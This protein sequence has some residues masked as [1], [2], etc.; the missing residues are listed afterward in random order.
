VTKALFWIT[1]LLDMSIIIPDDVLHSARLTEAEIRQELA[2]ALF[3]K[4][5][6][7]LGQASE[8]AQ[9]SAAD[10]QHLLAARRISLHYDVGDL[11]ADVATLRDS[12][13][14]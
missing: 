14:L 1:Y 7:S 3:Q 10:F 4:E 8:L 12:G 6:L 2:V 11:E 9:M 13:R 5:K